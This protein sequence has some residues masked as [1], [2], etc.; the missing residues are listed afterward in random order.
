MKKRILSIVILL[1][2][3]VSIFAL[4]SCGNEEAYNCPQCEKKL[5]N[6]D[7]ELFCENN[8]FYKKCVNKDC[9]AL[10]KTDDL[11]EI[12]SE[13]KLTLKDSYFCTSC[14][15][16]QIVCTSCDEEGELDSVYCPSCGRQVL[17]SGEMKFKFD[18]NA[19]GESAM[20]LCKGMLGIFIVTGII[21]AFILILNTVVEKI[22]QSK[23]NKE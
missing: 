12:T 19:L 20:I 13:N 1:L 6:D 14:G 7:G 17:Q 18:V 22:N 11:Y 10:I 5:T 9:S 2:S 15:T 23:K 21:I 4:S 8:H 16:N 3:L